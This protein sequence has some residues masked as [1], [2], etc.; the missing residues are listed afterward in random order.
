MAVPPVRPPKP[1]WLSP[2]S[3]CS[4][5]DEAFT[6]YTKVLH[7]PHSVSDGRRKRNHEGP[8]PQL[9]EGAPDP[10]PQGPRGPSLA[11]GMSGAVAPEEVSGCPPKRP[12]ESDSPKRDHRG[13]GPCW[14]PVSRWAAERPLQPG[15]GVLSPLPQSPD[16][17]WGQ[18]GVA[19]MSKRASHHLPGL[20]AP[21]SGW[22]MPSSGSGWGLCPPS[23]TGLSPSP[24]PAP[25]CKR[26]TSIGSL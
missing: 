12:Q 22:A 25:E 1:P 26:L 17:T 21:A 6:P 11:T 3:S 8:A 5:L 19:S 24:A 18:L 13:Q 14:V 20:L 16:P 4:E 10:P 9:M 2:L 23:R 7:K 15:K